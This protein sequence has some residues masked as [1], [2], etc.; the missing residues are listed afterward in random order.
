[1]RTSRHVDRFIANSTVVAERIRQSWGRD[2]DVVPPP[3]D[4][5]RFR[6]DRPPG[7]FALVVSRLISYKRIDLAVQACSALGIPLVV[8]GDGPDRSALERIAGP[9]VRFMGRLSDAETAVLFEQCQLFIL[10]GE[11]D[12]GITPLEANAAGRP[13]VAYRRGGVRDTI[14]DGVTGI[15]FD[16]D[17]PESLGAAVSGAMR[18]T[19]NAAALRAHA[20]SFAEPVFAA[21]IRALLDDALAEKRSARTPR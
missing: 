18:R 9:S 11:E 17:T 2:S 6:S 20:E 21:R 19:W 4:V 8:V 7:D 15:L 16:E 5:N 13:T 14:V 3:V 1:M 12:F 10:P